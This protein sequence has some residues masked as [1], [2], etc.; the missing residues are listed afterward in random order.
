M[1]IVCTPEMIRAGYAVWERHVKDSDDPA[2][3][4]EQIRA[5]FEAMI[6]AHMNTSLT[7]MPRECRS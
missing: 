5:I 1:P 6:A 4:P 7:R 2:L 3:G